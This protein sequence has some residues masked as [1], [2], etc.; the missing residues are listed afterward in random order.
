MTSRTSKQLIIGLVF[1]LIFGGAAYGLIDWFFIIEPTCFDQIQNGEEEG[2]DCGTLACGVACEEAIKP[3]QVSGEKLFKMG[4]GDY[5]FVAKIFNPNTS[6]G[7]SEVRYSIALAGLGTRSGTT[8]IL[9]GQTKYITVTSLRTDGDLPAQAGVSSVGL[10]VDFAE[11]EKLDLPPGEVNFISTREQFAN[12]VFEGVAFNDSNYDFDTVDVSVI[13]FDSSNSIIGI[14]RTEIKTLASK[15]ERA[16]KM[17]WPFPQNDVFRT[18][19]QIS[20]NLFENSNFIKS[21]GTQE[22]FQKFY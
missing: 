19:V 13:L 15:T 12:S 10:K 5:D 16:Y 9:P 6:Y 21:Y 8:Y 14:N 3:L 18:E 7:A 1:I 2:I 11:W 4:A 17:T 20:T 22:R